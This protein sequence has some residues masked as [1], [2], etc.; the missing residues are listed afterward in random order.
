M[1]AARSCRRDVAAWTLLLGACVSPLAEEHVATA[2]VQ[3][4]LPAITAGSTPVAVLEQAFGPATATFDQGRLR[5]WALML[6]ERWLAIDVDALAV[7]GLAAGCVFYAGTPAQSPHGL[8]DLRYG[9]ADRRL[10]AAGTTREQ[11]LMRLGVPDRVVDGGSVLLYVAAV[12]SGSLLVLMAGPG[13][14]VAG[15]S[16]PLGK[17]VAVAITFDDAGHYVDHRLALAGYGEPHVA[18]QR[19]LQPK[20]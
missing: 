17:S 20:Q 19:A 8:Q 10:L 3:Q 5:C 2:L 4:R 18:A 1:S 16:L 6:V 13:G 7:A 15:E 11:V 14:G 12:E 9:K